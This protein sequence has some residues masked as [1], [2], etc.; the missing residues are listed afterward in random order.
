M[1]SELRFALRTLRKNPG[2][3]AIMVSTLSV[4]VAAATIVYSTIDIAAHLLPIADRDRM[5][6][7]ASSDPRRGESRLEVSVADLVDLVNQ[8]TTIEAFVAFTLDSTNLTGTDVPVR[9]TILR[10]TANLPQI[11]GLQP[12]VGRLFQ[13][14]DGRL[15]AEPVA[16]LTHP[17]WEA[18]FASNQ[19]A[20]GSRVLLNDQPHTIVG[21]LRPNASVG[22]LR[23]R[24]LLVPLPLDA[25]ATARDDRNLLVTARLKRGVTRQVAAEEI[26]AIARQLETAYP[27]T[28]T[29]VRLQVLPLIELS[30]VNVRLLLFVLATVALLLVAIACAN[31][32]NIVLAQATA[33]R[34]ERAIRAALGASRV[35]QIRQAMI[36]SVITSAAAG[37][38]GVML[39]WWGLAALR[40]FADTQSPSYSDLTLNARVL[41]ASALTSLAAPFAFALIPAVRASRRDQSDLQDVGRSVIAN[42]RIGRTRSVIVAGQ[43]TLATIV[44][45]QIGLLT[46]GAE[47]LSSRSSAGL[48]AHQVL[49]FRVELSSAKYTEPAARAQFFDALLEQTGALPEV[50]SVGAID[51][52]PVADR[53]PTAPVRID[54]SRFQPVAEL[55]LAARIAITPGYLS[56]LRIPIV[57]GRDLTDA[58]VNTRSAVAIVSDEAARRFWPGRDPIG[59]RIGFAS[60]SGVENWLTVVG[61]A[62]NIRNS[63]LDQAPLPQVYL[64]AEDSPRAM[65]VLVRTVAQDPLTIVPRIRA[66][67]ARLDPNQPLHDIASMEQVIFND[68]LG[69]YVLVVLLASV[70][71]VAL[72]LA[73]VGIYGLVS[74]MVAQRSR[75]IGVHMALGAAPQAVRRMIVWQGSM[76]AAAGS[77]VGL[78]A[79]VIIA[80]ATAGSIP[81]VDVRDPTGYGLVVFCLFAV[82]VA[83]SYIPARRASRVD[84]AVT[85]RAE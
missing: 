82:A 25:A 58:E 56:T 49:T 18:H 29:N 54:G 73:A 78:A 77:I 11:W 38:I 8:S 52:L 35:Q 34:H 63:E 15:G 32:A 47:E 21:V 27:G 83:A 64:P 68:I 39:A 67:V 33:R 84:P 69:T 80:F 40:W 85:L 30:G 60:E 26:E 22:A 79:A 16:V 37:S 19:A 44:L 75:E 28:N 42:V 65:A 43:V 5:V 45:V 24:D 51:R 48:D 41:A 59:S 13:P 70:A 12:E 55:P 23:G 20:V 46:R 81:E 3:T 6:F 9:A 50:V 17:F 74:Y 36:E 31:V 53:E 57:R 1:A 61:V 10:T 66:E 76:P 4:A 72:G 14:Q 2:P 62:G 71:V 7:I